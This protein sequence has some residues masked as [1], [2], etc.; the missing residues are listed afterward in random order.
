MLSPRWR[1]VLRDLWG[2]KTRTTLVV[3]SIAIGVFA[4]GMIYGTNFLLENELPDAYDAINPPDVLMFT[5]PFGQDLLPVIEKIDGVEAV[6]AR[7]NFQ[8]QYLDTAGEWQPLELVFIHDFAEMPVSKVWPVEGAWPP[9]KDTLLIERASISYVNA[10]IGESVR[11]KTANDREQ[12]LV[13]SGTLHDINTNP[14]QFTG[15]PYAYAS[16]KT[17]Y[18]LVGDQLFDELH[19]RIDRNGEA[20]SEEQIKAVTSRIENKLERGNT[21]VYWTWIPPV[22][23]HPA[24]EVVRPMLYILGILGV[25]S[26]LL[27]SFLV[28]N[29]IN[30]LLTQHVQQIGIMKAIGARSYQIFLMYVVTVI[31]FGLVAFLIALPLGGWAAYALAG[32]IAGL[33]NFDLPPFY[34]PTA[35]VVAQL[36]VGILVPLLAALFPLLKGA[37]ISVFRALNDSGMGQGHFGTHLL[38]RIMN[39]WTIHILRLSRPMS[40]S[41]RNTIRRKLRLFMTLFTLTLGGAIFISILSVHASLLATLDDALAYFNYDVEISFEKAHRIDTIQRLTNNIP[42][43]EAAESWVGASARIIAPDGDEGENLFL[44]GTQS[45]TRVIQPLLTA[46]RWLEEEDTNGVVINTAVL[47]QQEHPIAVGDTITLK[48]DGDETQWQV[49]GLARSVMT[50]PIIYANQSYLAREL[51]FVGKASSVQILATRHDATYQTQLAQ[52]LETYFNEQGL[53]VSNT[54]TTSELREQIE[55]QFNIIVTLMVV[56]AILIASVGGLGLTGTMSINVLERT[57][58]IGIMRAVGA[59]DW[60]VARIVLVEGVFIGLLSWAVAALLSYPMGQLMSQGVG[61]SLLQSP[62]TY[63]FSWAG[64]VGWV[65]AMLVISAFASLVPARRASQLSVRE[66]LAYE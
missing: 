32:F 20:L 60:S 31:V 63:T 58:E 6:V 21:A 38:D 42:E 27:S 36:A 44:L 17:L 18:T 37:R 39:W 43:L 14:V 10:D 7:R 46:G 55:F 45:D 23:E 2:N 24:T 49:V 59:S 15:I 53:T 50:G 65:I 41:L 28:V 4:V 51:G 26:L 30:G 61:I 33:I 62:L 40:I 12:T 35:V 57:R 48:M 22:G 64:A 16:F 1:K 9:P 3:L 54:S 8:V 34:I 13:V 25:A 56:M 66:T 47:Q 29:I 5:A 52:A 19:V 11:I